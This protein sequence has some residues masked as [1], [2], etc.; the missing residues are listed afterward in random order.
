MTLKRILAEKELQI[1][2][3]EEVKDLK[4]LD[5]RQATIADRWIEQGCN[6]VLVDL[7]SSPTKVTRIVD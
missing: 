2:I 4:T 6:A 3:M 7:A 1:S 5:S